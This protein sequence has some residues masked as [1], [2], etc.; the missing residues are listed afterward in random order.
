MNVGL[1]NKYLLCTYYASGSV[2]GAK[3]TV[4]NETD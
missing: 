2:K 3:D 1:F 4:V